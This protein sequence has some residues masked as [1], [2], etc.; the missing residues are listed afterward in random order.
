LGCTQSEIF[1]EDRDDRQ[2]C[3]EIVRGGD[4]TGGVD[5]AA[6]I[7]ARDFFAAGSFFLGSAESY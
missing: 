3:D 6:R 1:A 7:D 2:R 5:D 4:K